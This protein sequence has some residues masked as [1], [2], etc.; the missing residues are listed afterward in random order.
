M[1]YGTDPTDERCSN[2]L[3]ALPKLPATEPATL[4]G[5]EGG[6]DQLLLDV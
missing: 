3:Y 4:A 1:A 6:R 2:P 5:T